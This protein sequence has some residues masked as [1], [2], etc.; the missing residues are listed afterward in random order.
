MEK[1]KNQRTYSIVMAFIMIYFIFLMIPD[2]LKS[3]YIYNKLLLLKQ[4]WFHLFI[5][6]RDLT[7]FWQSK[8]CK[9]KVSNSKLYTG[10]IEKENVS[11]GRRLKCKRLRGLY[12][13]EQNQEM[14]QNMPNQFKN[15]L[16]RTAID[17]KMRK[18]NPKMC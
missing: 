10:R 6:I 11:K 12:Q 15:G 8:V 1:T 17:V 4:Y 13:G 2:V 18:N 9:A 7:A 5:H 3:Y 14:L 16:I